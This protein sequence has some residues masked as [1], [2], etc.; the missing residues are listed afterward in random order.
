MTIGGAALLHRLP[1]P[2]RPDKKTAMGH[3]TQWLFS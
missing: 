1:T 2:P 3:V